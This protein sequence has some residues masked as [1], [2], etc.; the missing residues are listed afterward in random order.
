MTT[1]T[2]AS[3]G[4]SARQLLL[5]VAV[6]APVNGARGQTFI[7][8]TASA[9]VGPYAMADGMG[10]GAAAADYDGD[11]DVDVF[12][13][14]GSGVAD[15]LHRNNGDGTFTEIAAQVCLASTRSNRI[16]L[17]LDHEGDGDLDLLVAGDCWHAIEDCADGTSLRLYRHDDDGCFVD[18][19]A[20]AGLLGQWL[21]PDLTHAGG[22]ATGDLDGDGFLDIV[23]GGWEGELFVFRNGGDGTFTDATA[24]AGFAQPLAHYWQPLIA[25][26]DGDR[27]LDVF[28]AVDFDP[29]LLFHNQ[30]D[31]TFAQVGAAA[32]VGH[33]MNDMG[34]T[35]G[36]VDDDG[37]IDLYVT[38]IYG[39]DG[40]TLEHN[41][42]YRNDST[43]GAPSFT[44]VS[45]AAGVANGAWG[46]GTTFLDAD[47]DGRLDVAATNG[48]TYP[49]WST[50]TS[51]FFRNLGG[52]P[53]AFE[54]LSD[55]VGFDDPYYGSALVSFD[56]DRD[57][58]LDLLQAC[59]DVGAVR[60]LENQSAPADGRHWIVVRPRMT[61]PNSH[62]IGAVVRVNAGGVTMTRV[63]TAG[64][65][66]MG[67]EPAES[68]FGLGAAAVASAVSVEW[69]GGG[70]RTIAN[71]AGDRVLA[72]WSDENS[73][74]VN[75]DGEVGFA[76]L[77]LLLGEWG[78]CP[79]SPAPCVADVDGNGARGF[80]DLIVILAEWAG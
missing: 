45:T 39:V 51:R 2:M 72:V 7:D 53:V 15:Q 35:A 10:G 65:S 70:T 60:L 66:F 9:G 29:N 31:G 78:S 64:T 67:Q 41:L 73:A 76:D 4:R 34:V 74:D 26:L 33:V 30:G 19:T 57:G 71:V 43:S 42:L 54:D 36:D 24:A 59:A 12:V 14:N 58:D 80:G 27:R 8:V 68:F 13:P 56:Y 21:T 37:D 6:A 46:W 23:F 69:P 11:G 62:A 44:D 22:L 1:T 63:V 50:D 75:G 77:L 18:V 20:A 47:R 5:L 79:P 3:I 40:G 32:G 38:N 48:W 25:D 28:V 52:A 55:E 16:A 61:G 17:W 49:P